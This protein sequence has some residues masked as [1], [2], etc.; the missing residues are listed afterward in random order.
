[1]PPSAATAY[2]SL[3]DYTKTRKPVQD[4]ISQAQSQYDI[5]GYNTRMSGLRT[6][7]GNLQSAVENVDPQVSA[8]T[9]RTFTTDAQTQALVNRERQPLY[10]TLG[11]QQTALGNEEQGYAQASNNANNLAQ[12]VLNQDAQTY[13]QLLDQYNGANAQ[14]QQ[15]EQN[16]QW[17]AQFDAQNKPTPSYDIGS[18]L[19]SLQGTNPGM[20]NAASTGNAQMQ[21]RAGG[22]FNFQGSNGAAINAAQYSQAKGVP[23]RTLL[24]Q[25]ADSGDNGAGA[26]MQYVGNDYGVDRGKLNAFLQ[27]GAMDQ[28]TY[29]KTISLLR[30]LGASI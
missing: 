13:Q 11:K 24:K 1:M 25:M 6:Q 18:I 7:V 8:R 12:S 21:Q 10:N 16:R 26:A 15:Q 5:P 27:A 2:Q 23:F 30:S 19:K 28:A 14:E 22:G 3:T 29:N 17:Q 9:A 20:S 4:V